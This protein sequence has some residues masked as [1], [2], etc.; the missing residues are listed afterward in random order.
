MAHEHAK[1]RVHTQVDAELESLLIVLKNTSYLETKRKLGRTIWRARRKAKRQR[2]Q[3]ELE[4]ACRN[5]R[6]PQQT[7][8]SMHFNW[9]KIF[10]ANGDASQQLSDY[11]SG[12]YELAPEQREKEETSKAKCIEEWKSDLEKGTQPLHMSA[13]ILREILRKLKP[14]KI[15]RELD[16]SNLERVAAAL[17]HLFLHSTLP[18]AWSETTATLVPKLAVPSG[19]K[20]F[21]PIAALV[22]F[23]KL[24]GYLFLHFAPSPSWHPLQCGFVSGRDASQAVF[25]IMRLGE[26]A[27]EWKRRLYIAQLDMLKAFDKVYHSAIL[28]A[29]DRIHA[30]SQLKAFVANMLQQSSVCLNLGNVRTEKVRLDRGVI[31][32]APESPLLFILVSEMPLASL[33]DSWAERGLGYLIDGLWLPDVACADDVVLLA[34]SVNDLQ[35]MLL[36]VETAFSAVG[37]TLNLGKTNFTST[38]VCEGKTFELSGHTVKWSLRLTFPGNSNNFMQQR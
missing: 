17:N 31:Q 10:G 8:R 30:G 24:V 4:D 5:N 22:T 29:L 33:H 11:Y 6:C 23:R 28:A 32:G 12:V 7:R 35:T 9:S 26:V 25:C 16:E 1:P 14:G 38:V 20:D 36:E 37:L 19:P 13:D 2:T 21:R 3:R 27:K 18:Q 15:L 34:M